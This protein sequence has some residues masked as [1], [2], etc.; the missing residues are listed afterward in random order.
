LPGFYPE[1]DVLNDGFPVRYASILNVANPVLEAITHQDIRVLRFL[2]INLLP[3]LIERKSVLAI[4]GKVHLRAGLSP[5]KIV[6]YIFADFPKA[7]G[8]DCFDS[9][10][11]YHFTFLST[12]K[13][14][15]IYDPMV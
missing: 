5:A 4:T 6:T 12:F 7:Y 15:S 11:C 8:D 10:A 9:L 1:F 3:D 14:N 2:L 13:A